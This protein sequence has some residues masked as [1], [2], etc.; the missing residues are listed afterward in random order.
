M[1]DSFCDKVCELRVCSG[2]ANDDMSLYATPPYL[3]H[4]WNYMELV[5]LL[6]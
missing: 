5:A 2:Q 4:V 6:F 3:S 1:N